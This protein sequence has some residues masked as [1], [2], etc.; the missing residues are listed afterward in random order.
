MPAVKEKVLRPVHPNVGVEMEY[1]R[2]LIRMIEQMHNS[3]M[4][5]VESRYR[6]NEPS[7]SMDATPAVQLRLTINKL[8]KQWLARFNQASRDL[9]E[10][11]AQDVSDRSDAQL[12]AILK[13][14]GISV[15]WRMTAAQRDIMQATVEANVS[16]I[17]SIPQEYLKNVEGAVMRSVQTGRDL[18]AL[19]KELQKKFGVTKRKAA[20]ISRDQNNKATSAFQRARQQELGIT[21]AVWMHSHAGKEPR[22]THV[23]M[24]GKKYNV[25]EGMWDDDEKTYVW[26]GQLIN[27][28][29]GSSQIQFANGVEKAYRRR[30]CGELTEIITDSGKSLRATSNH[31]ILTPDGW[32]TISSLNEGDYVVEIADDVFR[33]IMSKDNVDDAVPLLSE[34]FESI[35]KSGTR[36]LEVG[37]T[38]QFHRD[39]SNSDVDVVFAARFLSFGFKPTLSQRFINFLFAMPDNAILSIR[40]VNQFLSRCFRATSSLVSRLCESFTTLNPLAFHTNTVSFTTVSD[41][42]AGRDNTSNDSMPRNGVNLGQPEYTYPVL[43]FPTKKSRVVHINN[44]AFDGHVYNLQTK[45]NWYITQGVVVHNCRC[46]SR[47]VVP[48]FS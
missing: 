38:D 6:N 30:Y 35:K 25:A 10:F 21:E 8:K 12:K 17:K 47:S 27:C 2:R 9:A 20:L 43:M 48:G 19:S 4:Y 16:L 24:N 18:G 3:V 37:T 40:F 26:P 13:K 36:R 1:R 44:A 46:T 39:G 45:D 22:K 14:G 33:P 7:I 31:P 28:F 42:T 15:K 23:A 41:F 11:F 29:P 34:I 32:K 5:W